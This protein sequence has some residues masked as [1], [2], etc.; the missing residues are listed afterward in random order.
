MRIIGCKI[1]NYKSFFLSEEIPFTAGFNVIVGQN[2]VG[3]TALVEALSLR[4]SDKP[5]RSLRTVP[6][7]QTPVP[8]NSH[9][10]LMIELTREELGSFLLNNDKGMLVNLSSG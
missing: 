3:K 7:I 5:H 9:V 4:F 1:E 10:T 6:Y 2:N 8:S